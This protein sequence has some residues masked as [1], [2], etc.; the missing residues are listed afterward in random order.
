MPGTS[1]TSHV[2]APDIYICISWQN[3]FIDANFIEHNRYFLSAYFLIDP[4][5]LLYCFYPIKQELIDV[6][7]IIVYIRC[8]FCPTLGHHQ[9]RIYRK[10][11]ITFVFAL[12]LCKSVFTVGVCSVCF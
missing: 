6:F 9:G 3:F 12:L 8:T 1:S 2:S 11:D 5:V 7:S 10:S 4:F